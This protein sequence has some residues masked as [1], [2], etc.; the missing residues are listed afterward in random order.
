MVT[1]ILLIIL[2]CIKINQGVFSTAN[3]QIRRKEMEVSIKSKDDVK[4]IEIIGKLDGSSAEKAEEAISGLI[5]EGCLL[6]IEMS[7]CDYVSSAGLRVLLV[8]A[9]KL[10]I[11]NGL[12]VTSGLLDEVKDV[13]EMTGFDNM[14]E[15]YDKL[16]EAVHALKKEAV[17]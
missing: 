14:F 1:S 6:V 9:K 17:K 3:K 10:K 4:I 8:T 13:M 5:V 15:N 12:A 11:K 16:D 7:Q 2:L